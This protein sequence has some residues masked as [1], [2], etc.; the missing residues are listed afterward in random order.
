MAPCRFC[1]TVLHFKH[2]QKLCFP[3]LQHLI[4]FGVHPRI[5]E[6]GGALG[7]QSEILG[8]TPSACAPRISGVHPQN[9]GVHP[10]RTW[11]VRGA[12][13]NSVVH[14]KRTRCAWGA[15]R[16]FGGIP[17]APLHRFCCLACVLEAEFQFRTAFLQ[18]LTAFWGC[19]WANLE[20]LMAFWGRGWLNLQY[21]PAVWGHRWADLQYL[22]SG[23]TGGLI[24]NTLQ[25]SGATGSPI[26]AQMRSHLGVRPKRTGCVFGA[27]PNAAAGCGARRPL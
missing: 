21:L 11:C 4:A 22:T 3:F 7:V 1:N 17:D 26:V 15:P 8:R 20:Y 5:S 9:S 24:F 23:A 27:P 18:Y 16:N 10:K 25:H 14:P 12:P 19:R 6:F 13:R 2:P